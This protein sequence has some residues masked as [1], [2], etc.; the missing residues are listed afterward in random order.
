MTSRHTYQIGTICIRTRIIV[1][2]KYICALSSCDSRVQRA[3][4]EKSREKRHDQ[5]KIPPQRDSSPS[6]QRLSTACRARPHHFST[7]P[8]AAAAGA[9][10]AS[11]LGHQ[12]R[13]YPLSWLWNL[14][15]RQ[16][17][18]LR[19]RFPRHTD[20]LSPY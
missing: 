16:I 11:A 3:G 15:S 13:L 6:S 8:A 9:T 14:E 2:Y 19:G 7:R 17:Q 10:T 12:P 20:R 1:L 18:C 4:R 5:Y